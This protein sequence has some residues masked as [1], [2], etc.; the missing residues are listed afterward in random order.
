M[1]DNKLKTCKVHTFLIRNEYNTITLVI[2]AEW[3]LLNQISLPLYLLEPSTNQ[4]E[5]GIKE[6]ECLPF[7][8]QLLCQDEV[9]FIF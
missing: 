7:S 2:K 6:A 1:D 9:N 5:E 8:G 3:S 4:D